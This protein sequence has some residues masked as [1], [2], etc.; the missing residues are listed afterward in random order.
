MNRSLCMCVCMCVCVCVFVCVCL[1]VC[2]VLKLFGC[3]FSVS[4]GFWLR[5]PGEAIVRQCAWT[6][7][8]ADS[9]AIIRI[10]V[11]TIID[12]LRIPSRNPSCTLVR[13]LGEA[14]NSPQHSSPRPQLSTSNMCMTGL[15]SGVH[16][17]AH[18]ILPTN[19]P[20]TKERPSSQKY[21]EGRLAR[22]KLS[23]ALVPVLSLLSEVGSL[24]EPVGLRYD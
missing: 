12:W 15:N 13:M 11:I 5:G 4:V 24:V 16:F 1:C 14:Q 21:L 20:Y 6:R 19:M 22:K 17:D 18:K 10:I 2:V 8:E 9:N 3:I 23:T 7:C